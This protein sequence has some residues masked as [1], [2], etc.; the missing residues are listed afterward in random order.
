MMTLKYQSKFKIT[1]LAKNNFKML[2]ITE[3]PGKQLSFYI[4]EL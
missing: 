4:E 2:L 3:V 1:P